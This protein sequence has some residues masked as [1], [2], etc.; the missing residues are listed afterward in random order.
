MGAIF[1]P[2]LN[3]MSKVPSDQPQAGDLV[4]VRNGDGG[5]PLFGVLQHPTRVQFGASTR[6]AAVLMARSFAFR[7][8]ITEQGGQQLASY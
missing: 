4:V 3:R 1:L 2:S 5:S 6:D 8:V 7:T